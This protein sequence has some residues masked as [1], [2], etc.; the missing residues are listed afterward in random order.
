[1]KIAMVCMPGRKSLSFLIL[2]VVLELGNGLHLKVMKTHGHFSNKISLRRE[3]REWIVPPINILENEDYTKKNPI[4]RI[5][6]DHEIDL[7]KQITYFIYGEGVEEYPYGVFVLDSKTGDLNITRILDRE[8][9]ELYHMKGVAKNQFGQE[10]ENPLDIRIRVLDANDNP[11]VFEVQHAEGYIQELSEPNTLVMMVYATDADEKN[12]MNTKLQYKIL[13][14]QPSSMFMIRKG[15]G[16]V[17]TATGTL[18]RETQDSYSVVVEARDLDGDIHGLAGQG[19]FHIKVL[20][21]NDNIPRL[22]KESYEANVDEN[23]ANVEVL[24]LKAFDADEEFSD[25][26]LANYEIVSGNE[27]G[28]FIVETDSKTNEGVIKVAKELDYETLQSLNLGVVVTNKAAFHSS[29]ASKFQAIPIPVKINVNNKVDGASFKPG[30]KTF[31]IS[32]AGGEAAGGGAGGGAGGA[33]GGAGG[34][35]AG[36]GGAEGSAGGT[37]LGFGSGGGFGTGSKKVYIGMPIGKYPAI[38]GD[39]GKPS[40]KVTYAKGTDPD[41]WFT[42]DEKTSEIKLAKLPDRESSYVVNGTY[43]A[44]ILAISNDMPAKTA[45]GTISLK[46][47][48]VNDHCPKLLDPVRTVCDEQHYTILTAHD[49]DQH[50][51]AEPYKF[52]VVSQ[53][54]DNQIWTIGNSNATSVELL[55]PQDLYPGNFKVQIKVKDNQGKSCPEDQ[56]LQLRVCTCPCNEKVVGS[57]AVLGPAAIGLMILGG[58]LLLLVP[59][60]LLLCKFGSTAVKGGFEPLADG[61]TETLQKWNSEGGKPEDK[62]VP[63]TIIKDS[64]FMGTEVIPTSGSGFHNRSEYDGHVSGGLETMT[65]EQTSLMNNGREVSRKHRLSGIIGTGEMAGTLN[66]AYVGGYFLEKSKSI[67]EEEDGRPAND[68]LMVYSNEGVGSPAG[69][70]GC[71]SIVDG[72]LDDTF[73]DDLGPKFKCLAELCIGQEIKT[74]WTDIPPQTTKPSHQTVLNQS[75]T[76]VQNTNLPRQQDISQTTTIVQK[77]SPPPPLQPLPQASINQTV[78]TVQSIAAPRQPITDVSGSIHKT[79]T[80]SNPTILIPQ[81]A[82]EPVLQNIL[83]ADG[84]LHHGSNLQIIRA[85]PEPVLQ[86][87]ILVTDQSFGSGTILQPIGVITDPTIIQQNQVVNERIGGSFSNMHGVLQQVPNQ[88]G[89]QHV[90]LTE[91]KTVTAPSVGGYLVSTELAPNQQAFIANASFNNPVM[92]KSV[93]KVAKQT[94]VQYS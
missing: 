83:I 11:P 2:A 49:P 80:V 15:T 6:S 42:I 13:S 5:R 18:D 82:P 40:E 61:T 65:M 14:Q 89:A 9:K 27:N 3:K 74:K 56:F 31:S 88:A 71:C 79:V 53:S 92:S 4:A 24:R 16:E 70:V 69:S 63:T 46:V 25:N 76:T 45:T 33:A 37:G 47:D 44:T 17:C 72:D 12:T 90:I 38:D 67:A 68:C 60:L 23:I 86:N 50:P 66:E 52:E 29:V 35:G 48:D 10:E 19:T 51:N 36:G 32:E 77:S 54:A 55:T 28:Y 85:M 73:L 7:K 43:T 64:R 58:L 1:M 91:R 26:W 22:E 84:S 62:E 87:H 78:T 59:L 21:V 20:D 41:N 39:T 30:I 75:R 94:T 81:T 8:E 93:S 34:G 57:N